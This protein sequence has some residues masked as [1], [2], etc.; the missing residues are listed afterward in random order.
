MKHL[1]LLISVIVLGANCALSVTPTVQKNHIR[2]TE[3]IRSN[4]SSFNNQGLPLKTERLSNKEGTIVLTY[5]ESLPD[6]IQTSLLAAKKL[7]ESKLTTIQPIFILVTFEPLG[8]DVSMI[9]DVS[10]SGTPGLL[11]C[12][13]ALASQI[14]NSLYGSIDQPDGWVILNSD[15]DWNCRFS[16]D[17]TSEYN[18]PTM[19]LRGIAKCLGFGSCT[20]EDSPDH[21]SFLWG[22]PTY[23]DKFLYCN[24]IA[25]S[26]LKE[27]GPEMANFVTSNN[28]Y[29][30][31]VSQDHKIYAPK[32]FLPYMSLCYFDDNNSIMSYSLGQGNIDLSI[33]DK[34]LD[35]LKTIGWNLPQEALSISCNNIAA[36]GIGS[37]YESHIFSLAKTN[38]KVSNFNWRFLLKNKQG[39]YTQISEGHSE[40][41]TID[42]VSSPDN[43]Y[44]NIN[45]DLEGR[46]ECDY[47]LNGQ[48]H[49]AVP[50]TLSL[51]LKPIIKSIDNISALNTGNYEFSLTFDVKYTGADYVSV[52]IEE[53]YNTTLRNY[54][55][56][57]PYIAHIKTGNITNLYYS[58]VTVVVSNKYGTTSESLEYAPTYDV[59]N[60]GSIIEE[61]TYNYHLYTG[62]NEKTDCKGDLDLCLSLP[63]NTNKLF[64]L[65]SK[66]HL[67]NPDLDRL[68]IFAKN[69][70]SVGNTV[71][72]SDI[73]WGTYF[74]IRAILA[75]GTDV[76][77]PIYSTNDYMN[78]DD[79]ETL[80]N[81]A[82]IEDIHSDDISLHINNKRL[83]ITADK[84]GCLFIYDLY[85]N[86]IFS[87]NINNAAEIPL[88]DVSSPFIIVKYSNSNITKTQKLLVK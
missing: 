61:V 24:S 60:A 56:D 10:L 86:Q 59:M 15:I 31:S 67:I 1:I 11:G 62:S 5:D 70:I 16:K 76:Y 68:K 66:P 71:A 38:E 64:F 63:K 43:F 12:P 7:W 21:F 88:D 58:W 39:G 77:S 55:F 52:E 25:L 6:S 44:I 85:G 83:Y 48:L 32:T 82:S 42:K 81:S 72:I 49:S 54:R 33:D 50:F 17:A 29:V 80:I 65:R 35:V 22:Y 26:D 47:S 8:E 37:S 3:S 19:V 2:Y 73:P 4:T 45:G 13:C 57:E 41:F 34:T 87:G 51:E 75:D 27:G 14:S 74:R 23:F 20:V 53:E 79:L 30:Q 9:A 28:V 18:L 78:K 69:E 46:I 36:N 40:N 84:V